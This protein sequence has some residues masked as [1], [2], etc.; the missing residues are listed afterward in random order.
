MLSLVG[1]ANTAVKQTLS[2]Q[3]CE[4]AR[5]SSPKRV[6]LDGLTAVR[7][8]WGRFSLTVQFVIAAS[9]VLVTA[10]ALV[11]HWMSSRIEDRV[12]Q[13][14][15]T[16]TAFYMTSL[17]EAALQPL[18]RSHVLDATVSTALDRVLFETQFG[19]T[20]AMIKVWNLDGKIVYSTN[21]ELVGKSFPETSGF[22]I[23]RGDRIA[24]E[25][26]DLVS[27][28][29]V[30]E[31]RLNRSLLEVYAPI[32][33]HGTNKVIGV[34]EMYQ[35]GDALKADLAKTRWDTFGVVGASTLGMLAS[36]PVESTAAPT[37]SLRVTA[38]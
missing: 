25:F 11:G 38:F 6:A 29:N 15:A 33:E 24:A 32:H 9:F 36:M 35:F 13:N 20:I 31:V 17:V 4:P 23:A 12:V 18:A 16:S 10:M 30:L 26:D 19:Q 21:K 34:A 28:E 22:K 14:T 8:G 5:A 7:A 1:R 37:K 3:P 2:V 27:A